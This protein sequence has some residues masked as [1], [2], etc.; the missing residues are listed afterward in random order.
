VGERGVVERLEDDLDLL[1][2]QLPVGGLIRERG[3]ERVHLAGVIATPDPEAHPAAGEHVHH[4][5]ILGEPE[6]MPHR[7]DVEAAPHLQPLGLMREVER[8]QQHVGDAFVPFA[9]EMVLGEPEGV[10]PAPVEQT[11]QVARLGEGADEVLVREDTAVH[12]G[13]A[14]ADVV[15]VHVAGVQAVELGDHVVPLS[16]EGPPVLDAL[17]LGVRSAPPAG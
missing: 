3:A 2:E 16:G 17:A 7:R 10:V 8:H 15:H 4:R 13:A 11:R 1:L 9:L 14:V 5:E 6:G 12:G